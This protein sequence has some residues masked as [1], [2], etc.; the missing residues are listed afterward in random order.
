MKLGVAP[1]DYNGPLWKTRFAFIPAFCMECCRWLWLER[2]YL[3]K[4]KNIGGFRSMCDGCAI[5]D[6]ALDD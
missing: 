3:R 2:Y 6:G 5:E 4:Y 1:K